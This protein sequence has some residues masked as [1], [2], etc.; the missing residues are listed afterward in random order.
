[1][2]TGASG[3]M[4]LLFI[5][6]PS[7]LLCLVSIDTHRHHTLRA[8]AP[9][10]HVSPPH[11]TQAVCVLCFVCRMYTGAGR[12]AQ[13]LHGLVPPQHSPGQLP[14]RRPDV[15]SASRWA[16]SCVCVRVCA[17]VLCACVRMCVYMCARECAGRRCV[18]TC[19]WQHRPSAVSMCC[20]RQRAYHRQGMAAERFE[21]GGLSLWGLGPM[22][23]VLL[24][25]VSLSVC[26]NVCMSV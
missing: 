23:V 3:D 7:G 10:L 22:C 5:F 19:M 24:L 18:R 26:V 14:G 21:Q 13:L 9:R 1:M 4:H 8:A 12:D 6:C 16:L 25:S 15:G 2:H 11:V 17:R 20:C